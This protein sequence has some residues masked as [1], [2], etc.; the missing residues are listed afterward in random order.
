MLFT[1]ANKAVFEL[2]YDILNFK[3][4]IYFV[5]TWYLYSFLHT[6]VLVFFKQSCLE[7]LTGNV[8]SLEHEIKLVFL[9]NFI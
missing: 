9:Q 4:V 7:Y 5:L 2:S 8:V 1:L 3:T 6:F